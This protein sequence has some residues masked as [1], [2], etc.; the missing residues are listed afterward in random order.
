FTLKYRNWMVESDAGFDAQ[1]YILKPEIVIDLS[2]KLIQ[3]NS[4]YKMTLCAV[5]ETLKILR[6]AVDKGD[7]K[8][9][10]IETRWL[11]ML[12][13]QLDGIPEDENIMIEMM[14][15]GIYTDKFLPDEYNLK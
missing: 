4:P 15:S 3:E 2:Q 8:L 11:N 10:D 6:E 7:L 9:N 12:S 14:K 1:A 5:D 13:M